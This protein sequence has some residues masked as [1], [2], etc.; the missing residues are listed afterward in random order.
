MASQWHY[1]SGGILYGPV[2][3]QRLKELA[4]LGELIPTDLVWKEGLPAWCPASTLK[5]LFSDPQAKLAGPPPL[6]T[7]SLAGDIGSH[8]SRNFRNF[9]LAGGGVFLTL[10]FLWG[11][12]GRLSGLGGSPSEFVAKIGALGNPSESMTKQEFIAKIDALGNPCERAALLKVTGVP[13]RTQTLDGEVVGV[14]WYFKCRDGMV[15]LVLFNPKVGLGGHSDHPELAYI[16]K[17][18][19]Y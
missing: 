15:Q 7:M 1:S 14:F 3:A 4:A 2:T 17:I 6:P 10:I 9:A 16:S 13:A 11:L 19:D 18:N 5:G 12:L 8:P